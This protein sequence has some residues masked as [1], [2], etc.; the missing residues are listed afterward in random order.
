M[1]SDRDDDAHGEDADVRL[2]LDAYRAFVS[3]D[4]ETATANMHPD[5]E[6]IEPDEFPDGGHYRGPAAVAA[7]LSRSRA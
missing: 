2:V 6:W 4:I 5:V 7:Y 1:S 3:G